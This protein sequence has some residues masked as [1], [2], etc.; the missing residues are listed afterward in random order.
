MGQW[1]D[2][3]SNVRDGTAQMESWEER[4]RRATQIAKS[5]N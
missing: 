4:S 5:S 1:D 2:N 3:D